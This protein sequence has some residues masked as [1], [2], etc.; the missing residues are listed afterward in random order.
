M[1]IK[2][3]VR[4]HSPPWSNIFLQFREIAALFLVP[5]AQFISDDTHTFGQFGLGNL[6]EEYQ[7]I[8]S[9]SICL[10]VSNGCDLGI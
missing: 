4:N 7:I 3:H 2:R 5:G 10:S 8:N 6:L 1:P 9:T